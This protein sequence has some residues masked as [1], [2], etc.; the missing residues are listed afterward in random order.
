MEED[1]PKIA[2]YLL[3]LEAHQEA[4]KKAVRLSS[5]NERTL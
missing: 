2:N 1:T 3:E 5:V 4:R